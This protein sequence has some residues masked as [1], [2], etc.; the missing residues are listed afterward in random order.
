[1]P[2][3]PPAAWR[4]RRPELLDQNLSFAP[5]SRRAYLSKIDAIRPTNGFEDFSLAPGTETV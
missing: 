4:P 3:N 2:R 5:A 1:M